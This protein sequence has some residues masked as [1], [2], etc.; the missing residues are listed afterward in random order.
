MSS[1]TVEWLTVALFFICFF[2]FTILDAAWLNKEILVPCG[3]ALSYTFATN[4]FGITI[5]FFVSFA[6]FVILRVL[7]TDSL[8]NF[9]VDEITA[10][11]AVIAAFLFPMILLVLAKRMM[12]RLFKIVLIES[13]WL[14][15]TVAAILFILFVSAV[16]FLFIYFV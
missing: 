14:Y 4:T 2:G 16:P 15:S 7:Y 9:W 12:L 6:I 5:G 11:A 8:Q 10:Q 1:T 3:K 13:P